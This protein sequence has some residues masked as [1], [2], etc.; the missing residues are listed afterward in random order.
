VSV[1]FT[2]QDLLFVK[3]EC[4]RFLADYDDGLFRQNCQANS[5]LL[6]EG[7]RDAAHY[8]VQEALN[9]LT[10]PRPLS[11]IRIGEGEGN[12]L[13]LL[14]SEKDE[15]LKW[16]NAIFYAQDAQ[17]LPMAAAKSFSQELLVAANNA[18]IIGFRAFHPGRDTSEIQAIRKTIERG[19][20][21]GALGIIRALQFA[22]SAVENSV[23]HNAVITSAWVYLGLLEHLDRLLENASSVIIIT[24]RPELEGVFVD[25]LKG[26]LT[27][28]LAVPI[29]ATEPL[30]DRPFHYPTRFQEIIEALQTD[31]RGSLVLV[32]AGIFA[33]IYCATAKRSGAVALDLGSGFDIL[34][35]KSTRPV[36]VRPGLVDLDK[37]AWIKT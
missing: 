24:G 6:I 15:E 9:A 20:V 16:F 5:R 11:M 25:K 34:A 12:V 13:G 1:T 14:A 21:R 10:T 19:D 29:E 18:D 17:L 33:K 22:K 35:G 28:F 27:A 37:L 31:L 2:E 3:A 30:P 7:Y 26:R 36:H 32:G 8:V 23:F 4:E